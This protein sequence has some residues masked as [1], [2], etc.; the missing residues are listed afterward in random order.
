[1]CASD[2]VMGA[3]LADFARE[4][5]GARRAAV[6]Y[7]VGRPYSSRLASAFIRRFGDPEA[8]RTW[9]DVHYLAFET[10]FSPQLRVIREFRPDVVFLPGSSPDATLVAAQARR[11]GLNAVFL[12]GDAW[13]SPLLFQRGAPPGGAYYVELCPPA[14]DFD[15][16]SEPSGGEPPGCRALLAYD[17]VRVVAAGLRRLGRLTEADLAAAGITRTRQRLRDAIASGEAEGVSG[18]IRFDAVGDR[19][20]GVALYAVEPAPD[21]PPHVLVRGWLGE[22]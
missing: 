12:G 9:I 5:L 6:L 10:D 3:L 1:M 8:G 15:R 17:A 14:P 20:Q 22:P 18:R 13:S 7:E 19:R 11:L 16:R 4:K 21:G 2:V